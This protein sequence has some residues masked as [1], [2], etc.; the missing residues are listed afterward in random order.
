MIFVVKMMNSVFRMM[1]FALKMV[2]FVLKM[3]NFEGA[4][5]YQNEKPSRSVVCR[6]HCSAAVPGGSFCIKNDE[7]CSTN[8]DFRV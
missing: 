7:L 4:D 6:S 8:D 1:D 2:D 3:M 5:C